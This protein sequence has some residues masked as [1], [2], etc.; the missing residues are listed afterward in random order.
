MT[1]D[2]KPF[3]VLQ[4][5]FNEMEGQFSPDGRWV[6]YASDESGRYEI[7]VRT[8]PEASG[9]WLVSVAGGVQPRWRR[10]GRELYYVAPDTRLMAVPIRLAPDTHALD[11]APPVPL[12]STRLATGANIA[13][14]GFLAR[15]QYAVAPDGRFLMLIAGNAADTSPITIVQHWDQD[16]K[17][18]VPMN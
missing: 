18:P 1:G 9:K 16:M 6:A 17:R 11:T 13:P 10:D 4:R 2:R 14:A 7:Y 8:F 3:A 15:A 12:F 5:S